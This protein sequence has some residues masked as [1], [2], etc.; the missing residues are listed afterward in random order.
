MSWGQIIAIL[1]ENEANAEA[2]NDPLTSCPIDGTLLQVRSDGALICP[3][4]GRVY[5]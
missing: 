5:G 2:E 3:F 1:A 4:D